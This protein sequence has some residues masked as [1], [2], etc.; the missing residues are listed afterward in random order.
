MN[1]ID[2]CAGVGGF[3]LGMM[4][5]GHEP[6][7]AYDSD[8][9]AVEYYNRNLG[10]HAQVRDIRTLRGADLP[11]ADGIIGGP[12]CQALSSA[13]KLRGVAQTGG[14][15]WE[16][17]RNLVPEFVRLVLEARPKFFVMENVLGILRF[18]EGLNFEFGRLAAAGY[19]PVIVK[20]DAA[21]YGV[22]QN[23]KRIFIIGYRNNAFVRFPAPTHTQRNQVSARTA[24]GALLTEP[25]PAPKYMQPY[26]EGEDKMISGTN[27][28]P[29]K[30]GERFFYW[31]TL[32]R[33]SFTILSKGRAGKCNGG[34]DRVWM[35]GN[36]YRLTQFHLGTLQSF[37]NSFE[38]PENFYPARV[39]AGNAVPPL[40]GWHIGKAL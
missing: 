35:S 15:G 19:E 6:I 37:P 21:N 17:D 14:W 39:L 31:R 40:L 34:I 32:D 30:R 36:C 4:M 12:P 28:P 10:P 26:C 25:T 33:P 20:V 16:S 2:L 13:N 9:I 18:K 38:W 29:Q 23:R 3:S 8:P 24:I 22:P 5:A 1:F 7:A 27:R 11:E